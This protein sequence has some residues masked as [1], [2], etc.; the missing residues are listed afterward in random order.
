MSNTHI[1]DPTG[2]PMIPTPRG[3]PAADLTRGMIEIRHAA[4]RADRQSA[5][6]ELYSEHA[7]GNL[8]RH[9][10]QLLD[11]VDARPGMR[12]LDVACGEAGL[13]HAAARRGLAVQGVD[14]SPVALAAGAPGL[15]RGSLALADGEALPFPDAW[16]DRITNIGSLEHYADPLAGAAEMA[17][18]LRP[19]GLAA[20]LVPNT[21]GLRWNVLHAW[22]TGDVHDDGQPL[23]RYAT[24]GQWERLLAAGGFSIE[25][26][27]GYE[28]QDDLPQRIGEIGGLARHPS[29]LL[30]PLARWLP[31]DMASMLIFICRR[32]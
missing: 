29:R 12:L 2:I 24:R 25:R 27:V 7:I 17:R 6:D 26:V 22:R 19:D 5:Y 18:V 14:L 20:I 10:R 8:V 13:L 3:D 16:F 30:I 11:L 28:K 1:G 23:Q 9:F 32:A 15:P 31:P 4:D 21:F